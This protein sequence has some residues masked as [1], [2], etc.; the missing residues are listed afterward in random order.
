MCLNR[1]HVTQKALCLILVRK[2][3]CPTSGWKHQNHDLKYIS[4]PDHHGQRSSQA[5]TEVQGLCLHRQ[6]HQ[7]CIKR[8]EKTI[9]TEDE[10]SNN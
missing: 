8:G 10:K 2:P 6:E 3:S 1:T 9:L 7:F 5:E 4:L